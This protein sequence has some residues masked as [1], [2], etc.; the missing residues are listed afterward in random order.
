MLTFG[1]NFRPWNGTKVLA[2]GPSI[3]QY[4]ADTAE[5]YGVAEHIRFGRRVVKAGWSTEAGRWTV[6]VDARNR[7]SRE[8]Y[9]SRF[10]V[11][12]TGYY[13]YDEGLRPAFPGEEDFR[14]G[15][16]GRAPAVLAR[17]PRL[18]RQAGRDHRQRRDRDHPGAR[19]GHR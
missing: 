5:E 16:P 9:T 11:G 19:D 3:K 4:V 12:A 14:R 13:N 1:F 10:L 15:R 2:D 7:R 18:R 6:E 8:I 17:R